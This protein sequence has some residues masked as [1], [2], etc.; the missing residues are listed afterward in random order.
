MILVKLL[1]VIL[2]A[3]M[4]LPVVWA[5]VIMAGLFAQPSLRV[6]WQVYRRGK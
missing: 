4:L 6:R 5:S 3:P 2:L 1:G